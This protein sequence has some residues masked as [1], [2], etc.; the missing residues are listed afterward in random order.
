MVIHHNRQIYN[1]IRT[2]N[3]ECE[4]FF[5]LID[6]DKNVYLM[7]ITKMI[8]AIVS[9]PIKVICCMRY[10]NIEIYAHF[11]FVTYSI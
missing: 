10:I 5:I 4:Q 9:T 8:F 1:H 11:C 6:Y 7:F 3:D 2:Y